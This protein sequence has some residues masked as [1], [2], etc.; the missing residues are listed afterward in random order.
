MIEVTQKLD[1]IGQQLGRI[2]AQY[3]QLQY[4]D[5]IET[6]NDPV[7]EDVF[8]SHFE[9]MRQFGRGAERDGPDQVSEGGSP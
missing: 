1:E 8:L 5:E 9:A 7:I 2:K 3:A 4:P 6:L